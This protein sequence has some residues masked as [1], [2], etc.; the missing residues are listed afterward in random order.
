M[1]EI[2]RDFET[3]QLDDAEVVEIGHGRSIESNGC[4]DGERVALVRA[5]G[6]LMGVGRVEDG[7]VFPERV[8]AG[9]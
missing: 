7:R 6:G 3:R 4:R 8:V 1:V 9:T 5:D 2:L